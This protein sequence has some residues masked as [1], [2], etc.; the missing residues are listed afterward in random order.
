MLYCKAIYLTGL[1]LLSF[2]GVIHEL[3]SVKKE[4]FYGTVNVKVELLMDL[5]LRYKWNSLDTE[6]WLQ[7]RECQELLSLYQKYLSEQQ[8]K[9]TMS[10]SELGASRAQEQQLDSWSSACGAWLW[11]S[12]SDPSVTGERLYDGRVFTDLITGIDQIKY[13]LHFS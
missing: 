1:V 7:Y 4:L 12:A 6:I 11:I 5:V 8:E 13:P 3:F 9:L 10:L 2:T